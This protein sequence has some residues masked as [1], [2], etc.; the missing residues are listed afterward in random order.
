MAT[1][2][3]KGFCESTSLHG[4]SYLY[5]ANS[6]ILKILWVIVILILTGIGIKFCITNTDEYL[7][8]RL[9]TNIESSTAPLEVRTNPNF[10][11]FLLT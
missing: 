4:Y 3:F 2:A 7:K 5:N 9:V 11:N 10:V 1:I 6:I 8:A